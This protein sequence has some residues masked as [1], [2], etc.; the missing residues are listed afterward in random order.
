MSELLTVNG[1][2]AGLP[3]HSDQR[4]PLRIATM[5]E[6]GRGVVADAPI[7][8]GQ[9][10]ERSPVLVIPDRD[11]AAADGTI[12]FTYVFMWEHGTTE[13]DLYRHK[14]RS[15]IALGYT[16]L[17]NHSYTPNC[18][19]IRHFDELAIDLVALR[20]IAAG[21]ELTIDYQMTL[22]FEPE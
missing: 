1:A 15:A 14:G 18:E 19:F 21:E 11:R 3:V 8:T 4:V 7:A 2:P 13:E 16:S 20:P 17:L 5:G 10:V 9:L 22:W 12:V 6:R